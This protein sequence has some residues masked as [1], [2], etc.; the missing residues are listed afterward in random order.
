LENLTREEKRFKRTVEGGV[1]K[2]ENLFNRMR[3]RDEQVMPGEQAF[4]LYATYGLPLEL[5]RDIAREN[6]LD[7]DEKGFRDAMEEHRLASGA[8]EAFG[9]LGVKMWMFTAIS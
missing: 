5:T 6:N 4:D 8:G 3:S 9:P 7:V 1:A 2:L